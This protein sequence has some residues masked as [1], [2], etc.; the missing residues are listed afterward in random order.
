MHFSQV[1]PTEKYSPF[2]HDK[3]ESF[4]PAHEM[5]FGSQ[6]VQVVPSK[7]NPL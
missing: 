5:H 2:W 4:V 1:S 7:T 3:Q 6:R